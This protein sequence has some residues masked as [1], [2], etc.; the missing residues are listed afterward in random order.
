MPCG[1]RPRFW[2]PID[3]VNLKLLKLENL[4][5]PYEIELFAKCSSPSHGKYSLIL[6]YVP[7]LDDRD[8][9]AFQVET[10]N[11]CL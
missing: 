3:L 8:L 2:D 5:R 6:V 7:K 1:D 9:R 11:L 4:G 10:F